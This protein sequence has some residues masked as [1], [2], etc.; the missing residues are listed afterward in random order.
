MKE[1]VK[2]LQEII[3]KLKELR[4]EV[5]GDEYDW[6]RLFLAQDN[7]RDAIDVL[8]G[9]RMYNEEISENGTAEKF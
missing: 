3:D 8:I 9:T 2:Q 7:L 5:S 4:I 1:I 6:V